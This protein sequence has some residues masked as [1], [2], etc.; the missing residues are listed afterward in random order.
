MY[1][2]LFSHLKPVQFRSSIIFMHLIL[3]HVDTFITSNQCILFVNN[4]HAFLNNF[5]N[6]HHPHS[7]SFIFSYNCPR[8]KT[9]VTIMAAKV[10][11]W[12]KEDEATAPDGADTGFVSSSV[13]SS[14]GVGAIE[15]SSALVKSFPSSRLHSPVRETL[16]P[17]P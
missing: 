17:A 12:L 8:I 6:K 5:S 3:P 14:V 13:G 7:L 1:I 15:A 11:C 9:N 16:T 2:H 10:E 4:L